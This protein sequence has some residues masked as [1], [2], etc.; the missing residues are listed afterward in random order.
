MAQ[1]QFN[2]RIDEEI[3]EELIKIAENEGRSKNKQIEYI[4]KKFI[5]EYKKEHEK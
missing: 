5:E 1:M 3:N 4:L 2:L